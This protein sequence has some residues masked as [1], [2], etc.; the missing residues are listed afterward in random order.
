[1]T[2]SRESVC[3]G[4]RWELWVFDYGLCERLT[5]ERLSDDGKVAYGKTALD[6]PFSVGVKRLLEEGTLLNT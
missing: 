3:P 1:M 4:Q 2:L 6:E 5:I